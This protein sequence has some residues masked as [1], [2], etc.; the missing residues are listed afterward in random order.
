MYSKA[1]EVSGVVNVLKFGDKVAVLANSTWAA[2][3]GKKAITAKWSDNK[4][5]STENHN[6]ILTDILD[7]K[8]FNTRREDGD[9]NKAFS[10][11]DKVIERTYHSP[12]LPHRISVWSS[13][14]SCQKINGL[15]KWNH[16]F[17]ELNCRSPIN[18]FLAQ[19]I[20]ELRYF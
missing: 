19:K 18:I 1:K 17:I 15:I 11:A 13:S 7:G 16:S 14:L 6:K 4:P 3:K 5:E 9:V 10:E 2:M 20:N 12:F 8:K